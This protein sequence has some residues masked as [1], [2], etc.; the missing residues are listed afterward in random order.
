MLDF[1]LLNKT[2]HDTNNFPILKKSIQMKKLYILFF[3][4][5]INKNVQNE[6]N[7]VF[8][9][10]NKMYYVLKTLREKIFL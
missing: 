5:F 2:F 9:N 8:I 6:N 4:N 10:K 1:K 7:K 3:E